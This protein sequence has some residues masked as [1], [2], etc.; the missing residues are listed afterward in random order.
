MAARFKVIV[1]DSV[2]ADGGVEYQVALWADVP[3][4]RQAF[5]ALTAPAKSAWKDALTADN[6]AITSGAVAE[7]VA[8]LRLA[9]GESAATARTAAQAL[10]A[11]WITYVTNYNPW[12][13]YGSTWDGTSWVAGGVA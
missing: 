10:S 12:D 7:Q 11:Q 9:P 1:L 3:A 4:A 5:W 2:P 6:T 8:K 13:R